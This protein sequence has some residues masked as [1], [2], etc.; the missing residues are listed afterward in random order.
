MKF[1]DKE[2]LDEEVRESI[3]DDEN[4]RV[5]LV[6]GAV[7]DMIL[8]RPVKDHD[9]VVTGMT[10]SI[11]LHLGFT[12]VGADFP[13]FLH[14][15][16]GDEFALARTERKSGTGYHGFDVYYDIDVTIEEDL[17]RRDLTMNSMAIEVDKSILDTL[18]NVYCADELI[19]VNGD[20]IDPYNGRE[21]IKNGILR[22]TSEAFAEDPLRVLRTARFSARYNFTIA[23]ETQMLMNKLSCS[24]ELLTLP[25]ERIFMEFK[26]ALME[27]YPQ[28]F[29]QWLYTVE[30]H[31]LIFEELKEWDND[32]L[33]FGIMVNASFE[34]RLMLL[35]KGLDYTDVERLLTRINASNSLVDQVVISSKLEYFT[36]TTKQCSGLDIAEIIYYGLTG[37][38]A[39]KKIPQ[40][41]K[42]AK[43]HLYWGGDEE[44]Y[45]DI[46]MIL[47]ALKESSKV[48]FNSL[49]THEQETLKGKEIGEAIQ[50]ARKYAVFDYIN[51]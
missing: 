18:N 26:K 8:G 46:F 43:V 35:C 49:S 22:H 38:N 15:H 9:F 28:N 13:V 14:P 2:L 51:S 6:G 19:F 21:D 39:W 30:A 33:R 42:A 16:T 7:R 45:N 41:Q 20:I 48:N 3:E 11:M 36:K 47:G 23:Q 1:T 37:M 10:E 4:V 32:G 25:V 17:V 5:Y 50:K 40:I 27:D 44:L 34:E 31:D 29:F 12:K 24:K